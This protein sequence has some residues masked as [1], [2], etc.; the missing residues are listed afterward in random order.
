[1]P[2]VK[3]QRGICEYGYVTM[4]DR[5]YHVLGYTKSLA[6]ATTALERH[7][8]QLE[9]KAVIVGTKPAETRQ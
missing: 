5:K 3:R 8:F 6:E 7:G 2:Y 9:G 4:N 1:M